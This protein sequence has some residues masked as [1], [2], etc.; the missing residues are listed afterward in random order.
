MEA[1]RCLEKTTTQSSLGWLELLGNMGSGGLIQVIRLA[2]LG[3]KH[4]FFFFQI[5][6]TI[7]L[8]HARIFAS[9]LMKGSFPM[10]P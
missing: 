4:F 3:S 7:S 2:Y 9:Q 1:G 5:H 6:E 8:A 10:P